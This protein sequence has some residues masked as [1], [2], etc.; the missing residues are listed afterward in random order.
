MLHFGVTDDAV[1]AQLKCS[2]ASFLGGG[3]ES[4]AEALPRG[5]SAE[6]L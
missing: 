3:G 6:R 4:P 1:F 2:I 5:A